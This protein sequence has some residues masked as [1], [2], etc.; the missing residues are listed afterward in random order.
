MTA[1]SPFLSTIAG[2][3]QALDDM[4]IELRET[5]FFQALTD[6]DTDPCLVSDTFKH[7]Y[8]SIA[9]FQPHVI[10]AAFTA[11]GRL[12]KDNG[13]PIKTMV[14]Q[15]VTEVEQADS[16]LR[17]YLR[18]DGDH[19][20]AEGPMFPECTAVAAMCHFLSEHCHPA[21]YLGFMYV[22][23][24]LSAL[25]AAQTQQIVD[26]SGDLS[27]AYEFFDLQAEEHSQQTDTIATVIQELMR[28]DPTAGSSVLFGLRSFLAVYPLPVWN[29]AYQR[30]QQEELV[31]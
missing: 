18:L 24:A 9:Q 13:L 26:A 20:L 15:Q 29:A 21:A 14:L 5:P 10:E 28:R 8:L 1:T 11:V 31:R 12:P 17:N 7:V 27:P 6:P 19:A 23:K 2:L 22:F 16:A 25:I 3:Q 30:A 4:M